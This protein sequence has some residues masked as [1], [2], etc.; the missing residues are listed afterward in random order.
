MTLQELTSDDLKALKDMAGNRVL[1]KLLE[2][3]MEDI[4]E[5]DF[6]TKVIDV[7]GMLKRE[8]NR[9]MCVAFESVVNLEGM[10]K[11]EYDMRKR[12]QGLARADKR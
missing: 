9:G 8:F 11:D 6:K 2:S 1:K 7:E 4:K 5:D 3:R 12:E 10:I